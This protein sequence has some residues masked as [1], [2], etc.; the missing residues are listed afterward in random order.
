MMNN[1]VPKKGRVGGKKSKKTIFIKKVR[2]SR[3]LVRTIKCD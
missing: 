2:A 1:E 3:H